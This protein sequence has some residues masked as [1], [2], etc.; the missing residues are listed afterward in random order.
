[1]IEKVKQHPKT[2]N[3]KNLSFV[4]SWWDK[5]LVKNSRQIEKHLRHFQ[6]DNLIIQ[7]KGFQKNQ[8]NYERQTQGY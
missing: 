8:I 1:M 7:T 6:K 4:N 2:I 3:E 5:I